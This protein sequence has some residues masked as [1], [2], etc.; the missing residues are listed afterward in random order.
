ME[1]R[2][3][4]KR[5]MREDVVRT[6]AARKIVLPINQKITHWQI[7]A[8]RLKAMSSRPSAPADAILAEAARLEA[9]VKD[10]MEELAEVLDTAAVRQLEAGRVLDTIRALRS[11][12]GTLDEI[13][14]TLRNG[15]PPAQQAPPMHV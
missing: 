9:D 5:A 4:R 6:R 10:H 15:P 7:E 8:A 13:R 14:R 11:L 2:E 12:T 3:H 1:L